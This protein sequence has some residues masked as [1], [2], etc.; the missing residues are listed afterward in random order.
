MIATHRSTP[1]SSL[2]VSA[3]YVAGYVE[4]WGRVMAKIILIEIKLV[5]QRPLNPI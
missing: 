4:T 5:L 3:L 2:I 1:R